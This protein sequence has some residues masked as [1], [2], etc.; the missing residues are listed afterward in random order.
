MTNAGGEEG[1]REPSFSIGGL[2]TSAGTMEI[3][4]KNSQK[5]K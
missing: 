4:V 2:Q 1:K 5:D 3:G